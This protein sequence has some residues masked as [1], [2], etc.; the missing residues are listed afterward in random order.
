MCWQIT[1][2]RI[3]L[4]AQ[5][6]FHSDDSSRFCGLRARRRMNRFLNC[7]LRFEVRDF[8]LTIAQAKLKRSFCS[9][10]SSPKCAKIDCHTKHKCF[11]AMP[12]KTTIAVWRSSRLR[13]FTRLCGIEMCGITQSEWRPCSSST[14]SLFISVR[15]VIITIGSGSWRTHQQPA[16]SAI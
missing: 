9:F 1:S 14:S 3:N 15:S 12:A 4:P 11:A 2:P 5:E 16:F 10:G 13:C 7:E 6:L 8:Q